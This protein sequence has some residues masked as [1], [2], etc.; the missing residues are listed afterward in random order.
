MSFITNIRSV[1]KYES[2]ILVR[3]WFFRIFTLLAVV[4]LGFFNFA[5]M[6]MEDN[7]GLW[8]AKSVSSNIPYLNL[9]LLNT[10]QAVVAVFLSSEFLK[11]DKK[12]DTSE[13]FYVRPL[14]N[15]EYVVGKIFTSPEVGSIRATKIRIKVDLPAPFG[16]KSPNIPVGISRQTSFNA[17]FPFGYTLLSFLIDMLINK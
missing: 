7:F 8:F 15:A 3:S 16:P 11:R 14:S 2:K 5:M 10:G 6:L 4:F 1:A 13:V 9:L 17:W 12:L